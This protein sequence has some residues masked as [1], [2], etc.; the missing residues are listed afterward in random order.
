MKGV[1]EKTKKKILEEYK[2]EE[3]MRNRDNLKR[4][5]VVDFEFLAV[6]GKG[7]FGEVRLV[8]EKETGEIY[9]LKIM[10]KEAVRKKNQ[11]DHVK[12]ERDVLA[13]SSTQWITKLMYSFQDERYLYLVMEFCVGGD[14]MSLL[15]REDIFSEETTKFYIAETILALD[16]V[17]HLGYIHRYY[18]NLL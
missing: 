11:V 10:L 5:S 2:K 8:R 15:I 14:V 4:Y 6:I 1:D 17:H 12:A 9:A 7:A 18:L 3:R 13:A 16:Y